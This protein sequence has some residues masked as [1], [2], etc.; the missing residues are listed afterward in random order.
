MIFD[1]SFE[2][3]INQN[4]YFIIKLIVPFSPSTSNFVSSKQKILYVQKSNAHVLFLN[5]KVVVHE[6]IFS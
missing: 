5:H 3:N 4:N 1:I 6:S 2:S